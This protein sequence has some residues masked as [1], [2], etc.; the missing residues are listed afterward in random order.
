MKN[1]DSLLDILYK[2]IYNNNIMDLNHLI[3][4]YINLHCK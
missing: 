4:F 2:H 1:P 3:Y